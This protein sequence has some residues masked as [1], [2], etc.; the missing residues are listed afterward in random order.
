MDTRVKQK[1]LIVNR[2]RNPL[3]QAATDRIQAENLELLCE[4]PEDE[5]LFETD[6]QGKPVWTVA[7]RSKT[8]KTI[9]EVM[10]RFIHSNRRQRKPDSRDCI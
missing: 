4:I 8:Y 5:L 9:G 10:H 3:P 2:V 7:N 1:Y 6:Q